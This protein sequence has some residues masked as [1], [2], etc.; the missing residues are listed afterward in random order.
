MPEIEVIEQ[1]M[2]I[3]VMTITRPER[4]NALSSNTLAAMHRA[5]DEIG[6]DPEI[7]AVVVTGEGESFCAG[8]DIKSTPEDS[9]NTGGTPIGTLF[10]RVQGQITTSF[11]AQEMMANLFEK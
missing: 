7:R 8:A 2:G 6:G 11:V 10:S 9:N 3:V 4:R 1:E 5:F